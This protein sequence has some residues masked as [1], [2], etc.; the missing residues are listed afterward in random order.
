MARRPTPSQRLAVKAQEAA[1]LLS[2]GTDEFLALVEVGALPPPVPLGGKHD[3][4]P[5]AA[6]EAVLTGAN[7]VEDDFET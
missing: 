7:L 1:G 2:L 6:L 4:W 3:L 5:V